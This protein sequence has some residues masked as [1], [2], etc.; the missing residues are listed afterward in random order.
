MNKGLLTFPVNND[1]KTYAILLDESL[2]KK[3]FVLSHLIVVDLG[4]PK[5]KV[6][7][8][9]HYLLLDSID[10]I[11]G[12]VKKERAVRNRRGRGV[13]GILGSHGGKR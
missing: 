11:Y 10:F 3:L 12:S 5:Q 4:T 6:F 1:Q 8:H 13:C 2:V 7:F 9:G